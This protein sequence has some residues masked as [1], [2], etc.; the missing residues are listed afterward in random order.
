MYCLSLVR[1]IAMIF[2]TLIFCVPGALA[3]SAE[4]IIR[5]VEVRGLTCMSETEL[6]NIMGFREATEIT[7]ADV[8]SGIKRAFLSMRFR[9]IIVSRDDLDSST[10]IVEVR[11]KYSVKKI[12]V[13]GNRLLGDREIKQYF[14]LKEGQYFDEEKMQPYIETLRESLV[15][16]GYV[17]IKIDFSLE[18]NE[19]ER[20]IVVHLDVKENE[21]LFIKSV[22]IKGIDDDEERE[23]VFLK[24]KM[25]S[26]DVYNRKKLVRRLEVI[27]GYLKDIG[28]YNP[29]VIGYVFSKG[30][31]NVSIDT[32]KRLHIIIKGNIYYTDSRLMDEMPFNDAGSI[33]N[34]LIEEAVTR[35]IGLYHEAGFV[36]TQIAPVVKTEGDSP[37]ILFYIYEGPQVTLEKIILRGN[38]IEDEKIKDILS[39]REKDYFNPDK[40]ESDVETI[41]EF[42]YALGYLD[43]E[44]LESKYEYSDDKK[45]ATLQFVINEGSQ[46][47]I[48]SIT[49]T[50]NKV[51]TDIE[52]YGIV[53]IKPLA[54]Y[55]ELDISDSRFAIINKYKQKG[56][57]DA[58]V[59][60]NRNERNDRYLINFQI[61]EGEQYY[62]GDT[63]I[64]GN[65]RVKTAVISRQLVNT[66]G[67]PFN[68]VLLR[69]NT[70]RLYKLGLFSN[71]DQKIV[72]DNE[73]RKDVL[74][75]VK[76]S[77]AGA[78]EFGVGY[79]DYEKYRGFFD[80]SYRN[81]FGMNRQGKFRTEL[82]TLSEKYILSGFEPWLFKMPDAYGPVAMNINFIKERRT[83]KNID[84]GDVRYKVKK[85]SSV[86]NWWTNLSERV[87]GDITYSF[88]IVD[89][90]DVQPDVVL[91]PDDTGTVAISK[92]GPGILYDSRDNPFNP[93]RGIL[94]GISFEVASSY[95]LS[96]TD[97]VKSE[98]GISYF[99][100]LAKRLVV[101]LSFRGGLADGYGNTKELPLVERF[102]L[103]GRNTVRGYSQDSLGPKGAN[104]TPIG[105]NARLMNN[106]EFRFDIGWDIGVV[107][108]MDA[109]N[110]W[111][112]VNKV[113][114]SDY[115]YT[116][117]I[118]LRYMTPV[119]P[120]RLDYGHKLNREA[121]ESSGEIHFSIGHAF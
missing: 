63:I 74:L 61:D 3:V 15:E 57:L 50:G 94:T 41:K 29:R 77:N 37:E 86:A 2:L 70:Q 36:F 72:D 18:F 102:V 110:V 13:H 75:D 59:R 27:K 25:F 117:G 28:Y 65:V 92:I 60:I 91:T 87:K 7:D 47:L 58:E 6:L 31:L 99:Y 95:I 42:Y 81:F 76:E 10:L 45:R 49:F 35:I 115:K 64:R 118:G 83:E 100:P 11:E 39:L 88:S 82:T 109:G 103:G 40:V 5:D 105:G 84:T 78:F 46:R 73:N 56:Y 12:S 112:D 55:N 79:G 107:L 16:I 20:E 33:R 69:T 48:R 1:T 14:P 67:E 24:L 38:L 97:F 66:E 23:K 116:T 111:L 62:F 19:A 113:D 96:Q 89:T 119:G 21:P 30:I 9:D 90:Y 54:P 43:I 4:N 93:S 26:G 51:F 32:G 44:V 68:A 121:G 114:L 22:N 106:I 101:A 71:I 108:F 98:F 85:Y 80:I 104:G 120:L 8:R 34:E 53:K 17:D 52:L